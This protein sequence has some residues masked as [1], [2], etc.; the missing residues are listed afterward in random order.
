MKTKNIIIGIY[1]I[2]SPSGKVYIGQSIDIYKR[3]RGHKSLTKKNVDY[4]LYNSLKKY[5]FENHVFEVIHESL[6]EELNSWEAH[7]GKL[8]DVTNREC[9]LN[10]RECGGSKGRFNQE[11]KD[12]MSES[13]KK[14]FND[15]ANNHPL[16]NRCCTEE[17]KALLRQ[18]N[19]DRIGKKRSK[20]S[21]EK[22]LLKTIGRKRTDKFK[23]DRTGEKNQMFGRNHTQETK[24]L[25][26]KIIKLAW[27]RRKKEGRD[28]QSTEHIA[29]RV[30][31]TRKTKEL[32]KQERAMMIF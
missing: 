3:W 10:L 25:Q 22:G 8:F 18:L 6:E 16:Y 20:D 28:R 7:Y 1:K 26:G 4:K 17:T 29:N 24:Q 30:E 2:T 21:I 11:V 27:V 15:P 19:I 14:R 32:I 23:L 5:G 9:G 12:K 31:S 13:A